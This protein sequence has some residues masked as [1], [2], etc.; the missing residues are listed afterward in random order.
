MT[1]IL[2]EYKNQE[3]FSLFADMHKKRKEI[4]TKSMTTAF[5]ER[6]TSEIL[7]D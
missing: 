4:T 7:E 6:L 5:L 1:A 2:I 3:T